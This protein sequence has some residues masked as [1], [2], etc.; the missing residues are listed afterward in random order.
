MEAYSLPPI[1]A[2]TFPQDLANLF[3]N[4]RMYIA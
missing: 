3:R 2:L 1:P 4:L